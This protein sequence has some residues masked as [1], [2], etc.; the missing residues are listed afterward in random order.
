MKV[1]DATIPA[2]DVFVLSVAV[3]VQ[4]LFSA[5]ISPQHSVWSSELDQKVQ[6]GLS[7]AD[8]R[9]KQAGH[10]G[11]QT[12]A[13]TASCFLQDLDLKPSQQESR[14]KVPKLVRTLASFFFLDS[15]SLFNF[16]L[17]AIF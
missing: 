3:S 6:P 8:M 1:Q 17:L 16:G 15:Y 13:C 12:T 10:S 4:I 14:S 7:S 5:E 11:K 9:R 2:L